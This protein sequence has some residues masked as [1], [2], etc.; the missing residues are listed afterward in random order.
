VRRAGFVVGALATW[1]AGAPAAAWAQNSPPKPE[2][3]CGVTSMCA[4][5]P[6]A[7]AHSTT[8]S[9]FVALILLVVLAAVLAVVYRV[10][11]A[12]SADG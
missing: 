6:A 2:T 12:R 1:C 4:H 5:D 11:V 3:D 10:V 8:P 9:W 7:A